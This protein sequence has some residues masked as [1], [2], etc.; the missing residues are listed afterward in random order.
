MIISSL[1]QM[2]SIV[3]R[4]HSL[5]WDGWDVVELKK[6]PTAWMKLNG[7]FVN[8]SWYLKNTF[9]INRDGWSI[10]HKYVR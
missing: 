2:E 1:E 8:G 6:S 5:S 4:N 3:Q 9:S 10:P 7:A